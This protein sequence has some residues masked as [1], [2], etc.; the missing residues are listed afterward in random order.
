MRSQEL[1]DQPLA[2]AEIT[3]PEQ[4][5]LGDPIP[6]R[7]EIDVDLVG[8]AVLAKVDVEVGVRALASG[9]RVGKNDRP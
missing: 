1:H 7:I 8:E 3:A 6:G 4:R 2:P 5:H 9:E